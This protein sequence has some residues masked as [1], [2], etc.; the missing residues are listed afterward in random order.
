MILKKFILS[1]NKVEQYFYNFILFL[2]F[3][4]FISPLIIFIMIIAFIIGIEFF[5]C[6]Y[7]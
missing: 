6:I 4:V 3:I 7:R 2:N 1:K 5:K